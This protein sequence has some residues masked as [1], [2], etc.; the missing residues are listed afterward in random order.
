MTPSNI[1]LH[2]QRRNEALL[3]EAALL[4]DLR[5]A[6]PDGVDVVEF[7][8]ED[9]GRQIELAESVDGLIPDLPMGHFPA[10]LLLLGK[11]SEAVELA[12]RLARTSLW[13]D[14][15]DTTTETVMTRIHARYLTP[16]LIAAVVARRVEVRK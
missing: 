9:T 7:L 8:I 11:Q 10:L 6:G 5:A 4:N 15:E 2:P 14:G 1:N 16:A 12:V 3:A 13:E